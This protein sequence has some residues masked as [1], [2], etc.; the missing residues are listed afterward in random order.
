MLQ[1]YMKIVS[2]QDVDSLKDNILSD[3]EGIVKRIDEHPDGG[4]QKPKRRWFH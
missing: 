2:D 4:L 1:D 3:I